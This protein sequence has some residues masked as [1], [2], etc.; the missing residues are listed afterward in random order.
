MIAPNFLTALRLHNTYA[1]AIHNTPIPTSV[2]A[3]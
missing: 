1:E 3:L 2:A